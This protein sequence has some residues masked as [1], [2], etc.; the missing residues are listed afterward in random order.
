MILA[1]RL[2]LLLAGLSGLVGIGLSAAAAHL[3][4][5]A[6]NLETAGR[7]LLVHAAVLVGIVALIGAGLTHPTAT[8]AAGFVLLVGLG[9][10]CGD[11]TLR[12]LH[13]VPLFPRA[14][15]IGGFA[16]MGG[17]ALIALCA[18]IP[19]GR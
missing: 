14:A 6:R 18:L 2:L 15:P 8:R 12:A 16:L 3:P 19:T 17:W 9:L 5:D 1:D 11:I 10:F 7:F 4:G 13:G